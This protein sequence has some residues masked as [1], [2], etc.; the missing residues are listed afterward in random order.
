MNSA[1]KVV[2]GLFH[3]RFWRRR[4][5]PVHTGVCAPT[6]DQLRRPRRK[7]PAWLGR[8]RLSHDRSSLGA[9]RDIQFPSYRE[10]T[11]FL[12]EDVHLLG[13]VV[14][15]A[16]LV[17]ASQ[18]RTLGHGRIVLASLQGPACTSRGRTVRISA[19]HRLLDV[20]R[21]TA[22]DRRGER[23]VGQSNAS[24]SAMARIVRL[25]AVS[26]LISKQMT[27]EGRG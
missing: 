8:A 4:G 2:R 20:L 7:L 13:G 15:A 12:V 11:P 22:S 6:A 26:Y 5:H 1:A 18:G 9:A 25:T 16:L 27:K 10:V 17:A 23:R 14:P 21:S 24:P 3:E 19:Q